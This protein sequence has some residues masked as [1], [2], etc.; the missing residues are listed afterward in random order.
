MF[1]SRLEP[2]GAGAGPPLVVDM[3]REPHLGWT[4]MRYAPLAK[5]AA[6]LASAFVVD[7]LAKREG[8]LGLAPNHPQRCACGAH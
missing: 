1:G 6:T 8:N 3:G 5:H 4:A 7:A 2:V